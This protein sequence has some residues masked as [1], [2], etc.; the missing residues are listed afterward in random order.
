M[1][2]GL[3]TTTCALSTR[4]P[5]VRGYV[6][7]SRAITLVPHIK[8]ESWN[9]ANMLPYQDIMSHDVSS[10]FGLWVIFPYQNFISGATTLTMS[11]ISSLNFLSIFTDISLSYVCSILTLSHVGQELR[12]DLQTDHVSKTGL[13]WP[14]LLNG[15][16]Q[17]N[18]SIKLNLS[19][20][21][22]CIF[23]V[24]WIYNTQFKSYDPWNYFYQGQITHLPIKVDCHSCSDIMS[25]Y[26]TL[27]YE[28]SWVY[29]I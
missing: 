16:R 28:V 7:K 29:L 12:L 22:K 24:S 2:D 4:C 18:E 14:L 9:F 21:G 13:R 23:N 20:L 6:F 25:W 19:Y 5:S 8:I 26:D 27:M 1:L 17:K 10:F 15:A 3:Y 11:V